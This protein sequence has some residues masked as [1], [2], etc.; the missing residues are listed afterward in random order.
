MYTH[1]LII[2]LDRFFLV[3]IK[4]L[5][6]FK[7]AIEDHSKGFKAGDEVG[8]NDNDSNKKSKSLENESRL[9]DSDSDSNVK[10]I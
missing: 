2:A 9:S 10:S 5:L 1:V 6:G 7:V 4:G 8:D 3:T